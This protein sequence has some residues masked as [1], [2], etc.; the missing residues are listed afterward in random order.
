MGQEQLQ[1]FNIFIQNRFNIPGAPFIQGPQR[2]SGHVFCNHAAHFEKSAVGPFVGC[3][4]GTAKQGKPQSY[5]R[6]NHCHGLH[7]Q[8]LCAG[9]IECGVHQPVN[10][11]VRDD[12]AKAADRR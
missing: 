6:R 8:F 7:N 3:Y 2:R 11:N 4:A 12:N 1:L 10:P 9:M 5:R